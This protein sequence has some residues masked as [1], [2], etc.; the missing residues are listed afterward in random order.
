MGWLSKIGDWL[1]PIGK[2]LDIVGSVMG[3]FG[4]NQNKKNYEAQKE[5]AQSGLRWKVEDAKAAGIHPLFALGAPAT[6]FAPSFI[7][8]SPSESLS[9]IGQSLQR[10]QNV[11]KTPSEKMIDWIKMEQEQEILKKLR[12]ENIGLRR[13]LKT[14]SFPD[15]V[16]NRDFPSLD[17]GNILDRMHGIDII[18]EPA[19]ITKSDRHGTKE[20]GTI[21]GAVELK[22]P[23]GRV[24][25][26]PPQDAQGLDE[27]WFAPRQ[28]DLIRAMDYLK[29]VFTGKIH[30]DYFPNSK[31]R[32]G[33]K[34]VYNRFTGAYEEKPIYY[35]NIGEKVYDYFHRR[36]GVRR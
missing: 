31:P 8:D 26:V 3:L 5:F 16:V 10:A 17:V 19:R 27:T 20:A 29:G 32:K 14:P 11:T 33:Y 6:Q 34:W 15:V 18:K 30:D 13:E 28:Y 4:N 23:G 25:T 12:L 36:K 7:N 24:T 21:P 9:R 1:N 35:R 2:G 22:L